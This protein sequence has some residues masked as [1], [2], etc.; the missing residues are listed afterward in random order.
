MDHFGKSGRKQQS[1]DQKRI[2]VLVQHQAG[3][4]CVSIKIFAVPRGAHWEER[5]KG[6]AVGSLTGLCTPIAGEESDKEE[7]KNSEHNL[8]EV[9]SREQR[10]FKA[11]KEKQCGNN[12]DGD[13]KKD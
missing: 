1:N 6:N 3:P 12:N 10:W 13:A 11:S 7:K 5:E 9:F 8:Q 2:I 4:V